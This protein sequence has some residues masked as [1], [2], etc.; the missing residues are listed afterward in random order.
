MRCMGGTYEGLEEVALEDVDDPLD[1]ESQLAVVGVV[2]LGPV[3]LQQQQSSLSVW[4]T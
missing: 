1:G 3:L 2:Q 4:T